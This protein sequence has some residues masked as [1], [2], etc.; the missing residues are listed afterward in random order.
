V[1]FYYG[2]TIPNYGGHKHGRFSAGAGYD[3][4][5]IN[6]E[7]LLDLVVRNGNLVIPRTG[8]SFKLLALTEEFEMN[9]DVLIKLNTMLKEG[10]TI[11]GP[12]PLKIANRK[13]QSDMPDMEGWLDK[14]WR[15][16]NSQNFKSVPASVFYDAEPAEELKA[17]GISSDILYEGMEFFTL[18]YTHYQK[19]GLDFYFVVNT[20]GE[21]VSRNLGF[22]QE[23][24]IP[25][26]WDPVTGKI[27][28]VPIYKKGN[29]YI[30]LPLTLAPYESKFV[31]FKP[32]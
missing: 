19:E 31:V 4:E 14:L 10:A 9:P 26:V 24:K 3:Y 21:W 30:N 6:T 12:K 2:D 18:D 11:I 15:P 1:L 17:K 29:E 23:N 13:I 25:E 8:A 20:T 32:C 27:V 7:I 28:E 16:F 5:I 22:R